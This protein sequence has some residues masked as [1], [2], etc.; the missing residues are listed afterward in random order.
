MSRLLMFIIFITV[1]TL[2]ISLI[3]Y[4]IWMRFIRDTGIP[5]DFRL[6]TSYALIALASMFPISILLSRTLPYQVSFILSWIAYLWLGM[7]MLLFFSTF[8]MDVFNGLTFLFYKFKSS[9]QNVPMNTERREFLRQSFAIGTSFV[10]LGMASCGVYTYLTKAKVKKISVKINNLPDVFNGFRI[11]QISDLHI[12]QLM[13]KKTLADI[14]DTVNALKPDLIAITGDLA[15]G[16]IHKLK[17]EI[18]PLQT[19]KA[20]Y[21]TYFVTGNHE[22]YNGV[23][24]WI[25]AVNDLGI[26]VLHNENIK[27]EKGNAFFYLVGVPDHEG[28]RFGKNHAPDFKKAF[29]EID[30]DAPS[31][32]LAH[33]P[34]AVKEASIY[35]ANLVLSGHTHGGQIWPF[36]YMVYLQQPYL[37]GMYEHNGSKLY[38]NQGTGCWGPP[39][40]IGSYNEITEIILS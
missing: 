1:G 37:K 13:T 38:V 10:V 33:Q 2:V 30:K 39:M 27:I 17:G 3:H 21:G 9:T 5:G 19:L 28:K 26:R 25:K 18:T 11:V 31:V 24:S 20:E 8:M 34:F 36:N 12:G 40:R 22:Y 32:L 35:G 15:D 23:D 6:Y 29:S 4:Y 14:V 7:M 16:S